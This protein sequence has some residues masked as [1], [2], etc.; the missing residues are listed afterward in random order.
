MS[1][2]WINFDVKVSQGGKWYAAVDTWKPNQGGSTQQRQSAPK[3]VQKP[4]GDEDP[5][6][7]TVIPF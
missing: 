1:G 7:D 4:M 5:F 2:D 6:A 3:H